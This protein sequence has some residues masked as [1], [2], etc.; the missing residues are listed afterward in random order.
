[1]I[2]KKKAVFPGSFDPFTLGHFDIMDRASQLFDEIVIA[3]GTNTSK[4]Y[5]LDF[6]TRVACI[7][8]VFEN[9]PKISVRGFNILTVDFCKDIGAQ[10]IVR[11]LRSTTDFDFE[12]HIAD[13]N[14]SLNNEVETVFFITK[15]QY[16]AITSTIVREIFKFG[17]DISKFVPMEIA[18]EMNSKLMK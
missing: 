16:G 1:M 18:H 17:G 3:I 2:P 12:R 10:F 14:A 7:E 4:N 13:M 11:G 9:N 6:D 5:L 15:P 8:K